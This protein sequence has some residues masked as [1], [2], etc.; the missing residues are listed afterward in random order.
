[1]QSFLEVILPALCKLSRRFFKEHLSGGKLS[2]LPE[3]SI[4][5][6]QGVPK[7]SCFAEIVFGQMDHL[8]RTKPNISTLAVESCII[9]V[10]NKTLNWLEAKPE[11][12]RNNLIHPASKG[13]KELKARF[14][15]RVHESEEKRIAI[16]KKIIQKE[17]AEKE[18]I[19]KQECTTNNILLHGL[20]QS[21]PE[22]DNMLHSYEN[23]KRK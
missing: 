19:R 15:T 17:N 21:E 5:S 12:E 7:T 6:L 23:E 3:E 20:W 8:L 9:F 11:C 14:G 1:M 13:I 22:V 10:N 4:L 16:Q 2:N 18:K